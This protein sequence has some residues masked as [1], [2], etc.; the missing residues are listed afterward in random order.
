MG[1]I[2]LISGTGNPKLA[3]KIAKE[4]KTPLTPAIIK[5]FVNGEIYVKVLK[6]VRGD[7][8]FFIQSFTSAVNDQLM[9]LLIMIDALKRASA[10]RI[11]VVCPYLC[12]GRQDRKIT[13]REPISAKLVA[14]L[15][16]TA[17]A[18]RVITVDLH[19]DAIQG[20]YNIPVDHLVG[21]PQ[22]AQYLLKKGY[23][24]L[25]IV[26]P[27][28]G[29]VKKANK[30]ANLLRASLAVVDKKRKSQNLDNY[31][32]VS[33]LIGEVK[34][35]TAVIVDDM[36]DSGGTITN[37]ANFIKEKGAKEVIICTTHALLNNNASEKL[38]K[39]PAKKVLYLDTVKVDKEKKIKKM[40][41][42]SLAPLLAKVIKR[43]HE[44]KSLGALF[45][46]EEKEVAL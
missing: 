30:M 37:V 33:F 3:Q 7:D 22:F 17:G 46:W 29:A 23:K 12:Y 42:L 21:Y 34:G 6:K 14:D 4:L 8:I 40:E 32:E 44:G 26:A 45:K 24:N 11:N 13:S 9:E 2:Q 39:C 43:I 1:K 20:F 38:A 28:V 18:D 10:G 27:D 41:E 35:K 36:I 25:V 5:T 16:T 19:A 31:S 15:I